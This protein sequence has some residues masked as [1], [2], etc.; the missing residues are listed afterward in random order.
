MGAKS[1]KKSRRRC[2][3]PT[4]PVPPT[5][6]TSLEE[7]GRERA[8]WASWDVSVETDSIICSLTAFEPDTEAAAAT[9]LFDDKRKDGEL[10]GGEGNKGT[11]R[12]F[13]VEAFTE[14]GRLMAGE[15]MN[16]VDA[17]NGTVW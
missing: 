16:L 5:T 15:S 4:P 10:R 2:E 6:R 9:F 3:L 13:A 8:A 17:M 14:S 11:S 12:G 7:E 1:K